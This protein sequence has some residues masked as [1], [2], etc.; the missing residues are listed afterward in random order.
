[1]PS[2]H[3][4]ETPHRLLFL[5][6]EDWYFCSHRLTLAI[7]ARNAG[8]NVAVAT[9][10]QRHG[11][12]IRD[13]GIELI[14]LDWSRRGRNVLKE[15]R[16][17]QQI[18]DV[19]RS[20]RPDLV[21]HVAAKPIIYG[22]IAAALAG[23]PRT[24]NAIAGLGY[25]FTSSDTAA[26]LIRPIVTKIYRWALSRPGSTLI[27]QNSDDLA[28]IK[29]AKLTGLNRVELI[30]GAGVDISR[31]KPSIEPP[32]RPLVVLP[33]RMLRD[34]GV[35][36]FA[37]AAA[38]VKTRFDARFALVGDAD[39][40]NPSSYTVTELRELAFAGAV[41]WWG[42]QDD[43]RAVFEQSHIVCLPSYREGLPKAL[44]DAAACGRPI[45]TTNVPGCRA[46]VR[47]GENGF[48]VPA[49]DPTA[50]ADALLRLL[51]DP[52]L[53]TKM[54]QAGRTIAE[55]RF[56]IGRVIEQTLALYGTALQR[57]YVR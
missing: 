24:V 12:A 43:M 37:A 22:S 25:V 34:K 38:I 4:K 45:V 28:F 11:D 48:L 44:I 27:V 35:A 55:Q 8:Y 15:A 18:A 46:V 49:G 10:V 30:E 32:G 20:W 6:T 40:H 56:S 57:A 19:Y 7:A 1:M 51:Q 36:E 5:V 23:V 50:L 52:Q 26:R 42:W 31:Y 16:A 9:R 54:G 14:P 21:H 39:S 3:G 13:A 41:E 17:I 33:A 53:R 47:D 29:S 2:A